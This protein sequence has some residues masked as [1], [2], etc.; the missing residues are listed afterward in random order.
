FI[1]KIVSPIFPKLST[2]IITI[3][4][5]FINGID[6]FQDKKKIIPVVLYSILLWFMAGL[7]IYILFYAFDLKLPFLASFFILVIISLAVAIP[8]T[9][10]YIGVFHFACAAG[11]SLLSVSTV[12]GRPEC[13]AIILWAISI[14]PV[15]VMGLVSLY[16]ENVSFSQ[17]KVV[18][19]EGEAFSNRDEK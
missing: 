9:P 10:G 13:F 14:F 19:S 1:K 16:L 4:Q 2:K 15:I 11:I 5:S 17:L 8:S 12:E 6:F 18:G 7:S 3:L